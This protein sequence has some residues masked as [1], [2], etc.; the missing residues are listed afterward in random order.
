M[1]MIATVS[2]ELFE[3]TPPGYL[4]CNLP[5]TPKTFLADIFRPKKIFLVIFGLSKA[6]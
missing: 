2:E 1:G 6:D 4:R 3:N 5:N